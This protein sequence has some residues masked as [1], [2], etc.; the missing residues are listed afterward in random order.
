M[1]VFF[2]T[3]T[4]GTIDRHRDA[5]IAT[6]FL[7]CF[8]VPLVPL[9]SVL[10]GA[11]ATRPIPL[12]LRSVV[13]AY[14][15][16]WPFVLA[17]ALVASWAPAFWI[18]LRPPSRSPSMGAVLLGLVALGVFGWLGVGRTS[19][20]DRALRDV[21]AR[22][23]GE[24]IDPAVLGDEREV[25]RDRLRARTHALLPSGD[26]GY[27]TGADPE[28]AWVDLALASDDPEVL[29]FALARARVEASLARGA[30]ATLLR[31][32]HARLA[33]RALARRAV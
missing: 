20:R 25:L 27:R 28:R 1:I 31:A 7:H 11:G 29:A 18:F 3:R 30:E 19:P 32:A 24:P 33:D 16:I 15:R 17:I 23:I 21:Y 8:F 5:A 9:S 10:I 4:Y 12:S 26:A 6:V 13:A 22:A 14:L 2:G